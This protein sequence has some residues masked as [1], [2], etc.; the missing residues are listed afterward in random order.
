[1]KPLIL[2]L[3]LAVSLQ[4]QTPTTPIPSPAP[5]EAAPAQALRTEAELNTLLGPIALYP[6]ALIGIILPASTAPANIVLAARAVD[7]KATADSIAAQPWDDSVKALTHYPDLLRWL[8]QNLTWTQAV[9][10]AFKAQPADVMTTMQRLRQQ[11]RAAGTLVDTPQQ[12][13]VAEE[14][15]VRIVPAQ[16]D[17]IYVPVYDPAVVYVTRT[18]YVGHRYIHFHRPYPCGPWLTYRPDWHHHNVIIIGHGHGYRY[19]GHHHYAHYS[20]GHPV[21]VWTPPSHVHS[22]TRYT[23]PP[24]RRPN[25]VEPAPS[26]TRPRTPFRETPAPNRPFA[27]ESLRPDSQPKPAERLLPGS[28]NPS[29]AQQRPGQSGLS[30]DDRWPRE[31]KPFKR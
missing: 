23:T 17:V 1:M 8:D 18:T 3:A 16:P 14:N 28:R 19:G 29:P 5:L 30:A 20:S 4:A 31:G 24:P 13:V 11:A 6:D 9:G 26:I 7:Q 12:L 10:E 27:R 22:H 21:R 15:T 25:A 2:G